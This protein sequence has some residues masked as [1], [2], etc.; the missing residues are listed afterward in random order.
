MYLE[1]ELFRELYFIKI[2]FLFH[3][4]NISWKLEFTNDKKVILLYFSTLGSV[5]MQWVRLHLI[6]LANL[7]FFKVV[8]VKKFCINFRWYKSQTSSTEAEV[9]V[10]K[11]YDHYEILFIEQFVTSGLVSR[12]FLKFQKLKRLIRDSIKKIKSI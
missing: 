5:L 1:K 10:K 11:S 3:K 2:I 7:D 8:H 4:S 6:T 9:L 12:V